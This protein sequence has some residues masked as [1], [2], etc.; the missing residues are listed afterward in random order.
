[1]ISDFLVEFDEIERGLNALRAKNLDITVIQ[2]LGPSDR[3][4]PVQAAGSMVRDSETN[5]E[6]S[7]RFDSELQEEYGA[8]LEAHNRRI[9]DFCGGARIGYAQALPEQDLGA[10]IQDAL[11][12]VG[13]LR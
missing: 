8:L 11:P 9:Q 4:P 12:A 2:V 5:E 7:V 6:V 3:E 10:W 1:M 13:L